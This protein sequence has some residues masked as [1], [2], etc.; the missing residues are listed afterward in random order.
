M[1]LESV[2]TAGEVLL[3]GVRVRFMEED[4]GLIGVEFTDG[5]G[6]LV[7]VK[8]AGAYSTNVKVMIPAKPEEKKVYRVI[9]QLSNMVKVCEQFDEQQDAQNRLRDLRSHDDGANL[10]VETGKVTVDD[11]HAAESDEAPF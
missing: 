7:V 3:N 5:I 10:S 1:K 11:G 9:G 8:V 2:K 6:G 4:K